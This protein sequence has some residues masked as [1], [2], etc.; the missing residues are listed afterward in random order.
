MVSQVVRA[1]EELLETEGVAMLL[2]AGLEGFC[3][4]YQVEMEAL[5]WALAKL[6]V[7]DSQISRLKGDSLYTIKCAKGTHFV[8][9]NG[10][11]A[12][13]SWLMWRRRSST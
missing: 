2:F 3:L 1:L 8:G 6:L 13:G 4:V 7:L 9:L 11:R 12:L 10:L 5:R